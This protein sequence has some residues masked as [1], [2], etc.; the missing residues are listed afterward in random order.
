MH[1]QVE[2]ARVF[3]RGRLIEFAE[4]K[5]ETVELRGRELSERVRLVFGVGVAEEMHAVLQMRYARVVPGC[6]VPRV[7]A[8]GISEQRP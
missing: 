8:I 1:R 3:A 4:R 6:H 2:A 5:K 7:E